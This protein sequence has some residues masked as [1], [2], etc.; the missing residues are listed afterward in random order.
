[1]KNWSMYIGGRWVGAT[2]GRTYDIINPAT[3]GKVGTAPYGGAEEADLAIDAAVKAFPD[4]SRRT[5]KDRASILHRMA[6]LM[7][8]RR[9]V[10]ARVITL[11]MGKPLREALA[12]TKISADYL[13]WNAEEAAR[14]YGTVIPSPVTGKRLL[15]IRQPV[16]PVAA[17]TPWNFP[18][19]MAARKVAPALAA[20]CTVVL[21][22]AL[23]TPGASVM[24]AEIAEEAGLPSGV[25]NL[26][27]GKASAIGERF[28]QHPGIRKLTF[29]GSTEVGK[30]LIRG[31]ADQVKKVTMELGGH[32]PFIVFEDADLDAAVRGAINSKFRNAGQTCICAN[33]IYV[34]ES[35]A[36]SFLEKF[37]SAVNSLVTGDGFA[38][39]TTVGP[40]IDEHA[41]RFVEEQVRDAM[42]KGATLVTG[43]KRVGG[44]DGYF[45]EPTILA[46]VNE[47]M[48]ITR[49]E[50]FGPV[51][52]V[53]LFRTEEEAVAKAN[54]T[55]YGLAAYFF[56]RDLHRM[57][58]VSEALE[59]GI[60]GCNDAVPTTVEGP[61]GG[62][63]ES[64]MGREGGPD[65]LSDFLET[66]FVSIQY[67][68]SEG[69]GAR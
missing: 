32:A 30:L 53:Y 12:E 51:A 17:I 21:K 35:I 64:G 26:V 8:E 16:G 36:E 52:P 39:D 59:Y 11:E 40:L 66:K 56:T 34:H 65:S 28:L 67:E 1:M 44:C 41:L 2:D 60:V 37:R 20:G 18:L 38:E 31:S 33:R 47:E 22:P 48:R 58:R 9:E 3:A 55:P 63:K 54:N 62:W 46:G 5:A 57:I 50:T 42:D 27:I 6:D 23:Q 49:E 61:F 24:F 10:L 43:G 45:F 29:T 68:T 7:D 25:L 19:S 4:W 13:R 69:A 14:S 15:A